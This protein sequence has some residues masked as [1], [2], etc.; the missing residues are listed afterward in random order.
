MCAWKRDSGVLRVSLERQ[1]KWG[2]GVE[3][4]TSGEI[5]VPMKVSRRKINITSESKILQ[6]VADGT[7]AN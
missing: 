5:F 7:K 4:A 1:R 2:G 3:I 6:P